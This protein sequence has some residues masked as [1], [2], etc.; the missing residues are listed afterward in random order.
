MNEVD[1]RCESVLTDVGGK[2]TD[3]FL[4]KNQQKTP[5]SVAFE[6]I[7]R[8]MS[9]TPGLFTNALISPEVIKT[10]KPGFAIRAL[11]P[12]DYEKGGLFESHS[13]TY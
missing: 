8:T 5:E 4:W 2:Q 10:L 6:S 7:T 12:S 9:Q 1:S 13:T 11:E 3:G